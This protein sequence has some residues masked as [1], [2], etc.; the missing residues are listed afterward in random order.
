MINK[1]IIFGSNGM[2]GRYIYKYFTHNTT[3]EII[4]LTRKDFDAHLDKIDKLDKIF[5]KYNVNSNTLVFN[6]IG[7]IP[8]Q[9]TDDMIHYTKINSTFPHILSYFCDIYN[10]RMIHPSTDCVFSGQTGNYN[11]NSIHDVKDFYGI[12]KSVG[13]KINCCI[14][15]TSIIG[16]NTSGISLVEW[17]KSNKNKSIN[18]YTNHIWNGITCLQYAKIIDCMIK[19]NIFWNG[20]RHIYSPNIVSKAELIDMINRQYNLNIDIN[21]IDTKDICNRTL[22]SIY[23]SVFHIPSLEDQIHDM[24]LFR[25]VLFN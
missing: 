17:I 9:G 7:A 6:A 1:L 15:R 18:G 8:H 13:E 3:L 23:P 22:D 19:N 16:E 25:D 24:Y 10:C 2:L 5:K 11:E 14:I 21:N 12:S 4:P 20:V